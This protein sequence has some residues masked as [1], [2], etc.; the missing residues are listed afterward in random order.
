[1]NPFLLKTNI[2]GNLRPYA[3]LFQPILPFLFPS[4]PHY[5]FPVLSPAQSPFTKVSIR[6]ARGEKESSLLPLNLFLPQ[7]SLFYF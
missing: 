7:R 1:M 3:Y 5:F 2:L 6:A 4:N